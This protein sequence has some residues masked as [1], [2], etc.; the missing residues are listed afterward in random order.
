MVGEYTRLNCYSA[1]HV[2]SGKNSADVGKPD[3]ML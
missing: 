3:V 1:M 2:C